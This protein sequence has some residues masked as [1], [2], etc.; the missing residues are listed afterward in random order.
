MNRAQLP[1]GIATGIGGLPHRDAAE[2]AEFVLATMELPAIPTLPKRSPAEGMIPQAMVGLEGITVG[3]YGSIAVDA[4]SFDPRRRSSPISTTTRSAA[5]ARSSPPPP[6]AVP[7]VK[8]QFVGP[9]TFGLALVRAGL[10]TDVAFEVAVRAVRCRVRNSSTSSPRCC[11]A[12]GNW[13]SSTNRRST[14]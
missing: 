3:Q 7:P 6:V 2:A 13:C 11:P 5:C 9:V 12:V 1:S 8:W 14:S 10:D 4:T